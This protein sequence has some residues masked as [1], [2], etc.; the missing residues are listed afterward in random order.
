[1]PMGLL[2]PLAAAP[3]PPKEDVGH[4]LGSLAVCGVN[5]G[6]LGCHDMESV[7]SQ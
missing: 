1:M 5:L 3:L 2:Y 7:M 6:S 4:D